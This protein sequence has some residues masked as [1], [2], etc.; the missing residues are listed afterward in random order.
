MLVHDVHKIKYRFFKGVT[1]PCATAADMRTTKLHVE[2]LQAQI[3]KRKNKICGVQT[4]DDR[5]LKHKMGR[6]AIPDRVGHIQAG[7]SKSEVFII[8]C[9]R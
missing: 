9:K 8:S 7:V 6:L 3:E 1:I 5:D 2:N 4:Y